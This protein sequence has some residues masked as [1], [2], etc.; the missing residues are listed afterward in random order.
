MTAP[1]IAALMER[2][3]RDELTHE[4]L[5]DVMIA[6]AERYGRP[7]APRAELLAQVRERFPTLAEVS[8]FAKHSFNMFVVHAARNTPP[9][10][11]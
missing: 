9:D 3:E 4:E 5:V 8:A 7:H 2:A 1:S 11:H 6:G 10:R